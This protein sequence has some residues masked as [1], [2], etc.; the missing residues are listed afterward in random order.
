MSSEVVLFGVVL[1]VCLSEVL[2]VL[3]GRNLLRF[4]GGLVDLEV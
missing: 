2:M 3:L 4:F 1:W